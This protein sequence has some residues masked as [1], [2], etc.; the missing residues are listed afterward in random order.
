M[1]PADHLQYYR[2]SPKEAELMEIFWSAG[3][4]LGRQEVLDR[5]A[6]A[7]QSWKPNSIHILINQ[8]LQKKYLEVN[9]FYLSSRKLG[10]NFQPTLTKQDYALLRLRDAS[11]QAEDEGIPLSKQIAALKAGREK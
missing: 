11:V 6:A 1:K 2:L 8:L 3:E 7:H 9:G 5:A 10:R 4:P